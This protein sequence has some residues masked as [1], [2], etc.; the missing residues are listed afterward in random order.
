MS[1]RQT[2]LRATVVIILLYAFV[3]LVSAQNKEMKIVKNDRYGIT[4]SVPKDW[5]EMETQS[6]KV[7][8]II[9]PYENDN[10]QFTEN[11]NI[12][13]MEGERPIDIEE[14]LRSP[15]PGERYFSEFVSLGKDIV[16]I[17]GQRALRSKCR[18]TMQGIRLQQLQY[19][20]LMGRRGFVMTF[21]SEDATF[22]KWGSLFERIAQTFKITSPKK[23]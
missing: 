16:S 4:I 20:F 2:S 12:I 7:L 5:Q 23:N 3:Y 19:T 10:D 14:L 17:G 21:T 15:E 8:A 6:P 9:R 13:Y 18:Y 1:T 22:A 11:L